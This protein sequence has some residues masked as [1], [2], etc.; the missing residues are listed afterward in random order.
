MLAFFALTVLVAT[1]LLAAWILVF[2]IDRRSCS[3]NICTSSLTGLQGLQGEPGNNAPTNSVGPFGPNSVITG[4]QG[5]QGAPNTGPTGPEGF[6]S[7]VTGPT[8]RQGNT[9]Q[10][11]HAFGGII[12]P[13]VGETT[14]TNLITAS[15]LLN[16]YEEFSTQIPVSF[17]T[18]SVD[19]PQTKLNFVRFGNQVNMGALVGAIS[20]AMLL[21][22]PTVVAGDGALQ[23]GV[24]QFSIAVLNQLSRFFPISTSPPWVMKTP[25]IILYGSQNHWSSTDQIDSNYYL[26]G[27]LFIQASTASITMT[28]SAS[29]FSG[30]FCYQNAF[31]DPPM[32]HQTGGNL[33]AQW[34]GLFGLPFSFYTSWNLLL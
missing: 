4:P 33:S 20:P 12:L 13:N 1:M 24:L 18:D 31:G 10:P 14:A 29:V 2:I 11:P 17:I 30:R 8:G 34:F 23:P 7:S 26:P 5:P 28:L 6:G 21:T 9:G 22:N 3:S 19:A 27:Q 25:V 15:N 32:P 16:Y